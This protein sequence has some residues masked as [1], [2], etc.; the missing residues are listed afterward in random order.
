VAWLCKCDCG[1][2]II[3]TGHQLRRGY[4]ASCGHCHENGLPLIRKNGV[5]ARLPPGESA[6]NRWVYGMKRAAK[7]RGFEWDLDKDFVRV[8]SK[9]P[10]HYC[11]VEPMQVFMRYDMNGGYI[12]NG[13]DRVDSERGYTK[14]NVVPCCG[15]CNFC[16]STI[17]VEDFR[18][19]IVRVYSH[20]INPQNV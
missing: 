2:E 18:D 15:T 17:P 13:L 20:W 16:K 12:Y 5:V 19:W 4:T 3:V 9:Q 14:D 11:G 8:L 6:F 1:G 10:C 7:L